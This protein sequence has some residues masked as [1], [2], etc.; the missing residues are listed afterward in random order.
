[1]SVMEEKDVM[2]GGSSIPFGRLLAV[3]A[4]KLLDTR[5]SKIMILILV[6]LVIAAIVGRGFFSGPEFHRL[7][8]TAG[9]GYGT[10]LPALGILTVT[11]EWSQRTAL[12][13]FTL[14]PRRWRVLAAKCVPPLVVAVVASGFAVLVAASAT[15]VVAGVQ[16]VGADWE[17]EPSALLGWAGGNVLL[18][19]VGLAL[20]MLFLNA[21]AAI[22][23][24]LSAPMLANIVHGLGS[25]GKELVEWI[26]LN[27]AAGVL[28]SG[29][30]SG[31]DAARLAVTAV[32][33]IAVPMAI[34]VARVVRREVS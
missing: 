34:G 33:W 31:G 27:T 26:D 18:M 8:G 7:V 17:V 15:A 12:T 28:A 21:P 14:E 24:F 1:M 32:L 20:G 29:E 22:V 23:V 13:T 11:S 19:G 30:L 5:G 25:A 10:L 9:I 6:V 16:G 4:R 3:E 2:S